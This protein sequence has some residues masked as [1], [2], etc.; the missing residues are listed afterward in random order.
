MQAGEIET[1]NEERKASF[2]G[3]ISDHYADGRKCDWWKGPI[4]NYV[5]PDGV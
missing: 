5:P 1:E 2:I 4:E 3:E